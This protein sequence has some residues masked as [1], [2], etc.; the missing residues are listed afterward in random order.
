MMEPMSVT[1]EILSPSKLFEVYE[2]RN[3]AFERSS[4]PGSVEAIR[5]W[6]DYGRA[7]EA[8]SET[9]K[10]GAKVRV[11]AYNSFIE[12]LMGTIT[13]VSE[14]NSYGDLSYTVHIENAEDFVLRFINRHKDVADDSYTFGALNLELLDTAED[15]TVLR[16]DPPTC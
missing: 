12:G 10:V 9:L 8:H 15:T 4:S 14:K 7:F 1:T 2:L 13:A 5:A 16:I 6:L 11:A 3:E